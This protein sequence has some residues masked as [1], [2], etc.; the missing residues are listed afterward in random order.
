MVPRRRLNF[1]DNFRFTSVKN[2]LL[3]KWDI[4][5]CQSRPP[6][7]GLA[8]LRQRISSLELGRHPDQ[9]CSAV[10]V[11]F[12]LFT[13]RL[14]EACNVNCESPV[15]RGAREAILMEMIIERPAV[16]HSDDRELVAGGAL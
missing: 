1:R 10:L 2:H 7:T 16:R 8:G 6:V 11:P 15:C 3:F 9:G 5:S 14:P 4:Q 12:D 13:D